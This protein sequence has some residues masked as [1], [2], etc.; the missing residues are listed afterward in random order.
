MGLL[1]SNQADRAIEAFE[2]RPPSRG[3][4]RAIF[5]Q[6]Y[7]AAGQFDKAAT[8]VSTVRTNVGDGGRSVDATV[9]LMR[10]LAAPP[11]NLPPNPF[12]NWAQLY[13]GTPERVMALPELA[14]RGR[15]L[16]RVSPFD[17]AVTQVR[18]TARYRK[19]VRD[20]GLLDYWR[21]RGWPDFCHPTT[22]DD[23]VCD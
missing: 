9:E 18:Q 12:L 19:F 10:S 15:M 3:A 13:T 17:V 5:A 16:D 20:A 4:E 21:A 1:A 14:L 22:G 7:A 11:K 23:F 8:Q 6:A 2:A